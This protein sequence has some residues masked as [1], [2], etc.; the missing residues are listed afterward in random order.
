MKEG[1]GQGIRKQIQLVSKMCQSRQ[2]Q[3]AKSIIPILTKC[4]N[5][6]MDPIDLEIE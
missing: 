1:R 2:S 4:K 6:D 5:S 3:L